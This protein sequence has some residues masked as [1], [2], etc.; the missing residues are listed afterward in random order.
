MHGLC[1]IL[2]VIYKKVRKW[3]NQSCALFFNRGNR[4][5]TLD[6]CA[7]LLHGVT[8]HLSFQH[9][10]PCQQVEPFILDA[11][12]AHV[13]CRGCVSWSRDSL[14]HLFLQYS[15]QFAYV[16]TNTN[17]PQQLS[18]PATTQY[19]GIHCVQPEKSYKRYKL[20]NNIPVLSTILGT[21]QTVTHCPPIIARTVNKALSGLIERSL[22]NSLS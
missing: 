19:T 6:A 10:C 2:I 18:N 14:S 5:D 15:T 1:W 4:L 9:V 13:K 3:S 20:D 12:D 17:D 22:T 7:A 16:T 8:S 11:C 21:M